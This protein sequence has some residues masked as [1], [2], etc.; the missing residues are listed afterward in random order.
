VSGD[1]R[2]GEELT[3]WTILLSRFR[4][5]RTTVCISEPNVRYAKTPAP[6]KRTAESGDTLSTDIT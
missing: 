6:P 4:L 2:M 5:T 1:L 3:A